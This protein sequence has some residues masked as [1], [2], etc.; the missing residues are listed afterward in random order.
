MQAYQK[1]MADAALMFKQLDKNQDG[2]LS[3]DEIASGLSDLGKSDAEIEQIIVR[4]DENSDGVVT[5]A[6]FENGFEAF[7]KASAKHKSGGGPGGHGGPRMLVCH[8]CGTQHG[9]ASL[10]IHQKQCARKR[11]KVQATLAPGARTAPPV[12]PHDLPVPGMKASMSKVEEY[13]AV[14][15][16]AFNSCM[17]KCSK[18]G[19]TFSEAAT[20]VTHAKSCK[21]GKEG[22]L[23]KGGGHKA[24]EAAPGGFSDSRGDAMDDGGGGGHDSGFVPRMLVCHL[25]GTQHGLASLLIHQKQCIVKREKVQATLDPSA[26]TAPPVM[27]HDLPVPGMKATMPE[28]EAYNAIA[29]AAFNSCMPKC[30]NCGRT[31]SEPEKLAMHFKSCKADSAAAAAAAAAAKAAAAAAAAAAKGGPKMLVCYLC[32][33]QHGIASLLIHQKQCTEAREKEIEA[34]LGER[35]APPIAPNLPVPGSDASMEEVEAYNA[36]ALAAYN[37]ASPTCSKCGRTFSDPEKLEKHFN[38]CTG[39]AEYLKQG[40]G[41]TH[42][43]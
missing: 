16:A 6:E 38:H 40:A 19:R 35:T 43:M 13:N 7:Q 42:H 12:M 34:G 22:Y 36:A 23:Q 29:Q 11:E 27:P 25:C 9:L 21:G 41:L 15:Q 4:L 1:Q 26:R 39:K 10:L 37:A 32:G 3:H 5:K 24:K 2:V 18:C 28:V 17:P 8:L 33:T 14:A 31:F 30:S 20:L